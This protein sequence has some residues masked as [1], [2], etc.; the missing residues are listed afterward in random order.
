METISAEFSNWSPEENIIIGRCWK[1][2]SSNITLP[3]ISITN[4]F[5]FLSGNCIYFRSYHF[6]LRTISNNRSGKLIKIEKASVA[7]IQRQE[8]SNYVF[9]VA[10]QQ[11]KFTENTKSNGRYLLMVSVVFEC[12]SVSQPQVS[13]DVDCI[14]FMSA[15]R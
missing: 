15:L 1:R 8:W 3:N 5:L 14:V 6:I 10:Q 11:L 4:F 7:L 9:I 12:V 13:P 2:K